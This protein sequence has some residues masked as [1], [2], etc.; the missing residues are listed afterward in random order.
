ML[1]EVREVNVRV[2]PLV[3]PQLGSRRASAKRIRGLP[4]TGVNGPGTP[5]MSGLVAVKSSFRT[6]I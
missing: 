1:K 4:V 6:S 3:E 2:I 5:E